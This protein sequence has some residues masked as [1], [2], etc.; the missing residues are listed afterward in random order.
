M[1]DAERAYNYYTLM[2][3]KR[4]S[5]LL[6]AVGAVDLIRRA[7]VHDTSKLVQP[8]LAGFMNA[9]PLEG[10][11]YH[12]EEYKKSVADLRPTL[13]HHWANNRHH[14]EH[15]KRGIDDMTLFD[16]VEMFFDWKASSER[17]NNGNILKSIEIN[18]DKFNMSPQLVRILE[19]TAKTMFGV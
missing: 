8:E 7:V 4:V 14:P 12:S 13:E 6:T 19:N 15:H 9:P 5:E 10:I 16:V 17:H 1:T 18:G 2:H 11:T 3:I